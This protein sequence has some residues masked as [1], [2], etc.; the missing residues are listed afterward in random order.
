MADYYTNFSFEV[1]FPTAAIAQ[2]ALASIE[3]WRD[4][5]FQDAEEVPSN[6][7]AEPL[8]EQLQQFDGECLGVEVSVEDN[9][10]WVRDD[11]G[12]PHVDLLAAMLQETLRRH[13]SSGMIEFEWS[14]DCSKPRLDG[15]G[16]GAIAVWADDM[17]WGTTSKLLEQFRAEREV[18]EDEAAEDEAPT[19]AL[20]ASRSCI[21]DEQ[22]LIERHGVWGEHPEFPVSDWRYQVANNDDRRG[23]WGW[24]IGQLECRQDEA[25]GSHSNT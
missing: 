8:P 1:E 15:F 23:Y 22:T 19:D 7:A 11:G 10:L 3:S 20:V 24:V 13:D 14:C 5:L 18:E 12:G 9:R 4:R 21:P 16:G 17:K 6:N 25:Q 2:Q